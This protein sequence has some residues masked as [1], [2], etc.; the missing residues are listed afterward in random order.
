MSPV[1]LPPGF[2]FHPTDEELVNYYLKRKISGQEIEL[3]IIPE[4]DLYKCEPWELA[5]S[6]LCFFHFSYS[7]FPHSHV[8]NT[9]KL[10]T[11]FIFQYY[12]RKCVYFMPLIWLLWSK[13]F[14][15][16]RPWCNFLK[17]EN[18]TLLNIYEFN[19]LFTNMKLLSDFKGLNPLLLK[20][21]VSMSLTL[22]PT[23]LV[24]FNLFSF[25]NYYWYRRVSVCAVS[26]SIF[27]LRS[28]KHRFH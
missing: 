6:I 2:R 23:L 1:G 16:Q 26:M 24:M 27:L 13:K 11:I 18:V 5:G 22:I 12:A 8:F 7:K 28:L 9:L 14:L 3:D 25:S 21:D 4:V 19:V 10:Y 20:N 15:P 17:C